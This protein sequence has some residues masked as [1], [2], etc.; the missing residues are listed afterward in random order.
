LNKGLELLSAATDHCGALPS[1]GDRGQ[2]FTDSYLL[3]TTADLVGWP[4]Y[5][6]RQPRL[7]RRVI[8]TKLMDHRFS[9]Q[10]T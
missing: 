8:S 7:S 5:L 1:L 6:P 4:R 10:L 9:H 3:Q 2:V